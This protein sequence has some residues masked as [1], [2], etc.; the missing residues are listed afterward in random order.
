MIRIF[1]GYINVFIYYLFIYLFNVINIFINFIYKYILLFIDV[2]LDIR[3]IYIISFYSH[4]FFSELIKNS[5][6]FYYENSLNFYFLFIHFNIVQ[7]CQSILDLTFDYFRISR[8][9]IEKFNLILENNF[10]ISKI[11]IL[12]L[13]TV[14]PINQE[15]VDFYKPFIPLSIIR[16]DTL[17]F[18][19][20]NFYLTFIKRI[21]TDI[22]S[23]SLYILLDDVVP[24]IFRLLKYYFLIF[25]FI[26][27]FIFRYIIINNNNYEY[28]LNYL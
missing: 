2:F 13:K 20:V 11:R 22:F 7:E 21:K 15:I 19:N 6:N 4:L 1:L 27:Y 9:N 18:I 28:N 16:G 12:G 3:I 10:Y 23:I 8:L 26:F 14:N 25:Y 5:M 17:Y 24:I